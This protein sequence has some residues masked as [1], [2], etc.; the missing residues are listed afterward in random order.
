MALEYQIKETEQRFKDVQLICKSCSGLD[1]MLEVEVP[2]VSL[3]CNVMY[4]RI[5][6]G[7]NLKLGLK[8]WRALES[9]SQ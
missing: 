9:L 1:T 2:C 6:A 4:A 5:K 3:D 7:R 8:H